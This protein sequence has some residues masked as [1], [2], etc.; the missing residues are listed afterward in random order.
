[1]DNMLDTQT[2][3][4]CTNCKQGALQSTGS[5]VLLRDLLHNWEIQLCRH[6][7]TEVWSDYRDIADSPIKLCE[8]DR[9]GFQVFV[10]IVTGTEL[11]YREIA[12]TN[13]YISAKWEF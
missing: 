5:H 1:M 9:C 12:S 7:S 13:Y 8:C 10:P 2:R 6:F 11:F 4:G 3:Q